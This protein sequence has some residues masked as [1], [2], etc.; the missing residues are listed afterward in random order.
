MSKRLD[1]VLM[2]T[3][4]EQDAIIHRNWLINKI[5]KQAKQEFM[6]DYR[7]RLPGRIR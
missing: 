1:A 6:R 7:R 4:V 2:E 5:D 3:Y